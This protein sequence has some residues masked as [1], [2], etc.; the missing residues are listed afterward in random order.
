MATPMIGSSAPGDARTMTDVRVGVDAVDRELARLIGI[1]FAFMDAASRVKQQRSEVRDEQ[2]K[3]AVVANARAN[4]RANGWSPDIAE[5]LWEQLVEASIA[6]EF[7][8]FD[9]LRASSAAD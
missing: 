2:R 6:Y 3:A 4:A 5:A 8:A 7:E 1:R 9:A